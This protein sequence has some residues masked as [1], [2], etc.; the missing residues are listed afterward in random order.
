MS[1]NRAFRPFII[2]LPIATLLLAADAHLRL[3]KQTKVFFSVT[4]EGFAMQ[5]DHTALLSSRPVMPGGL[6]VPGWRTFR[7]SAN[8]ADPIQQRRFICYGSNYLGAFKL[9]A[10]KGALEIAA[11]PA[12]NDFQLTGRWFS[13]PREKC[14]ALFP[15]VPIGD[16]AVIAR[17]DWSQVEK[18][19]RVERGRTNRVLI[20]A[21]VGDL[22]L[23]TDPAEA[24]FRLASVDHSDIVVTNHA[25]AHLR[26]LPTGEYHL[27]VWRGDYL[28]EA[29]VAITHGETNHL[30][31]A[32][33]YGQAQV[34]SDPTGATVYVGNQAIGQTP[35]VLSGLKPGRYHFRLEQAGFEPAE[36]TFEVGDDQPVTVRTN[37]VNIRYRAAMQ[38]ARRLADA[39]RPDWH[40]TLATLTEALDAQPNDQEALALKTK[41]ETQLAVD[42]AHV[43]ETQ[44]RAELAKRRESAPNLFADETAKLADSTL[45]DVHH[46]T[47]H[48]NLAT[49]CAALRRTFEKGP[50][51]SWTV[52]KEAQEQDGLVIFQ[53]KGNS[54]ARSKRTC[55]VMAC[56]IGPDEIQLYAKFW[57]YLYAGLLNVLVAGGK[58]ESKWTPAHPNYFSPS[59]AGNVKERRRQLPEE[60]WKILQN[61]LR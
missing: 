12:A 15:A 32:F 47:V 28:K 56:Q 36:V 3:L 30:T 38:K 31:V 8:D 19:I 24:Q 2:W 55:V 40:E 60:F 16:Y 49:L 57:D 6:V 35:K 14:P 53:C 23:V 41:V 26:H 33:E 37:L 59:Q 1:W 44:R 9:S 10:Q 5:A 48:A 51:H 13:A 45:F 39:P 18:K 58:E 52:E 42:Q 54:S 25:P 4:V 27:R 21:D 20:R 50:Q 17:Y 7:L 61:E 46:W 22:D 11:E 34:V 43:A 29:R